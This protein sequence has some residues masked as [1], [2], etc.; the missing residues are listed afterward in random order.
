MKA[1]IYRFF[2]LDI[3]L[4]LVPKAHPKSKM[5]WIEWRISF[6]LVEK[7]I[8]GHLPYVFRKVFLLCKILTY[9]LKKQYNFESYLLKTVFFWML[10]EWGKQDKI[11]KEND[12]LGMMNEVFLY[13]SKC[14]EKKHL[15]MYFIPRI[16]LLEQYQPVTTHK[17]EF[18]EILDQ[19]LRQLSDK[20]SMM[21]I[22]VKNFDEIFEH[23]KNQ[24]FLNYD[25][26]IVDRIVDRMLYPQVKNFDLRCEKDVL[27]FQ[28][29]IYLSFLQTLSKSVLHSDSVIPQD[30]HCNLY[31]IWVF[32]NK[33][34]IEKDL[35]FEFVMDYANSISEFLGN[36]KTVR[37]NL[38][39]NE[40][41]CEPYIIYLER[42]FLAHSQSFL[43]QLSLGD[44]EV[45]LQEMLINGS[46]D[47]VLYS[48]L[49][50]ISS[51]EYQEYL[52]RFYFKDQ[53]GS[54]SRSEEVQKLIQ[55]MFFFNKD[56]IFHNFVSTL[57][58][59][60]MN[61]IILK[62]DIANFARRKLL[63]EMC[64]MYNYGFI[65]SKF[66]LPT[67]AVY[68]SFLSQ[69]ALNKDSS[70]QIERD[71]RMFDKWGYILKEE[72]SYTYR[73]Y[74]DRLNNTFLL[75]LE[76]PEESYTEE[77]LVSEICFP[78]RWQS[79]VQDL[80]SLKQVL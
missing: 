10:E 34:F 7:N 64:E 23:I 51:S 42:Y 53:L 52:N 46:L 80:L 29:N 2:F 9:E 26:Q 15:P 31:H 63:F 67:P 71:G 56:E 35:E 39:L 72:N 13:M 49:P 16:N 70:R 1:L 5:P 65:S 32:G 6:S 38:E 73:T 55:T 27:Q 77:P 58:V 30:L 3:P 36:S 54:K 33:H 59:Q 12:I 62:K 43:E 78:L 8:Y 74:D 25:Y 69:L 75:S 60:F 57:N 40:L 44:R 24:Q 37:L 28:L 61:E 76:G 22:V 66:T 17:E 20:K 18:V 21:I 41:T 48:K 68:M 11:F 4:Y 14:Y 47:K 50:S 45:E 19:K 79:T